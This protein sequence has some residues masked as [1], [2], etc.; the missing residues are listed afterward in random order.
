M[1]GAET[2]FLPLGRGSGGRTIVELKVCTSVLGE[3]LVRLGRCQ[4][5]YASAF[6]STIALDCT[7]HVKGIMC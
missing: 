2:L 5:Q 4:S 6:N 7:T 1:Y 3:A